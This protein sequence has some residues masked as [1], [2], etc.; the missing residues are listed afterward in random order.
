MS[1]LFTNNNPRQLFDP[2]IFTPN[3]GF[4]FGSGDDRLR[5]RDVGRL[6]TG[7]SSSLNGFGNN[8]PLRNT[9]AG[10]VLGFTA[11]SLNQIFNSRIRVPRQGGLLGNASP[12]DILAGTNQFQRQIFNGRPGGFFGVPF[13]DTLSPDANSIFL[14]TNNAL[15]TIFP[16]TAVGVPNVV[17]NT[18]SAIGS[19]FSTGFPGRYLSFFSS[20]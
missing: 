19:G 4:A 3:P 16:D 2:T 7:F 8:D 14:G 18:G 6:T 13:L 20:R 1:S 12:L 11:S 5:A 10:G 15:M 9:D 17:S